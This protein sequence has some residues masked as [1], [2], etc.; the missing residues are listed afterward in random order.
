ML[1]PSVV[2]SDLAVDNPQLVHDSDPEVPDA[3]A[4]VSTGRAFVRRNTQGSPLTRLDAASFLSIHL[5]SGAA[6]CCP[7]DKD[8]RRTPATLRLVTRTRA[9][10]LDVARSA[11]LHRLQDDRWSEGTLPGIE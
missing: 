5:L 9:P 11:L 1:L 6:S 8:P 3:S 10:G 2:A 4:P 7:L